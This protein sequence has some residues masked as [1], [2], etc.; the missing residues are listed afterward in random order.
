V[1]TFGWDGSNFKYSYA[2][3]SLPSGVALT[4]ATLTEQDIAWYSTANGFD[5]FSTGQAPT[6]AFLYMVDPTATA[7]PTSVSI[8][9]NNTTT[10]TVSNF[11]SS[12]VNIPSSAYGTWNNPANVERN[13]GQY[14]STTVISN[15]T[16]Y[17]TQVLQAMGFEFNIPSNAYNISLTITASAEQT[18]AFGQAV[19]TT[20][21]LINGGSPIG[22]QWSSN[23][24]F[25]WSQGS[26]GIQTIS[27]S[28][29]GVSLTP[30]IVNSS[31]FGLNFN[32]AATQ[33]GGGTSVGLQ[34]YYITISVTYTIPNYN[35][36]TVTLSKPFSPQQQ[37]TASGTGNSISALATMTSGVSVISTTPTYGTGSLSGWLTGWTV[38]AQ[39]PSG[40]GT[41]TT[42]L[43]MQV[44]G[45]LTYLSG[46]SMLA[47]QA[48]TYI[49]A[50]VATIKGTYT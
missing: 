25:S 42:V 21:Q 46:T 2:G 26:A 12:A 50:A 31:T 45:T 29:L 27:S 41:I 22:N 35:T 33:G 4:T 47:A 38:Q 34:L 20:V 30:A 49:N 14:A 23:G 37:G 36:F 18:S 28:L 6:G 16:Q 32:A 43:S 10:N 44:T 39:F 48:V 40:T 9:S 19:Y 11:P 7:G 17:S 3:G 15:H 1:V 5:L 8:P 13:N 24:T